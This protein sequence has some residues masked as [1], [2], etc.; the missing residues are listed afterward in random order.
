MINI[1]TIEFIMLFV[2]CFTSG[3]FIGA[4]FLYTSG[5]DEDE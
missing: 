3:A 1:S 2:L 4:R 5:R